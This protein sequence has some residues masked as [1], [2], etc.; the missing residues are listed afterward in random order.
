MILILGMIVLCRMMEWM[1]PA[2]EIERAPDIPV[3][4]DGDDGDD[5]DGNGHTTDDDDSVHKCAAGSSERDDGIN[6][7]RQERLPDPR[8]LSS[9]RRV[10]TL[11]ASASTSSAS[12]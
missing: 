11:S 1:M 10:S 3:L 9:A 7:R 12:T 6:E 2:G 5:G 4:V 8:E